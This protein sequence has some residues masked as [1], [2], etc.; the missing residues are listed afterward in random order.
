[1]IND[2]RGAFRACERFYLSH[3]VITPADTTI[4]GEFSAGGEM[5]FPPLAHHSH[6]HGAEGEISMLSFR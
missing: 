3:Y 4:R 2:T 5:M 1:M 6:G